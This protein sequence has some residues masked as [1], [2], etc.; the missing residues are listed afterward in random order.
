MTYDLQRLAQL[1]L[2][3]LQGEPRIPLSSFARSCGID[4]HTA[5]RALR[6]AF[7]KTYRTLQLECLQARAQTLITDGTPRSHKQLAV[8]VG[9]SSSRALSRRLQRARRKALSSHSRSS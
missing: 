2:E 6:R 7:N 9:Y 8:A 5:S 1:L 3:R 4:R